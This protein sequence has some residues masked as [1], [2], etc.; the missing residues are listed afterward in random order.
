MEERIWENRKQIYYLLLEE[1]EYF[2][3]EQNESNEYYLKSYDYAAA[4][5]EKYL[6]G[7]N[8]Y[9]VLKLTSMEQEKLI[10]YLKND[11]NIS[12]RTISK[13]TGIDEK[14]IYRVTLSDRKK[15]ECI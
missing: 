9:D 1:K 15:Q 12:C 2:M 11:A 3:V 14:K 10:L 6:N 8:I 7:K 13:I 4:C 5:V